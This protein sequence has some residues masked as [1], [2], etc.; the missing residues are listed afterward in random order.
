M[1]KAEAI[2]SLYN[3]REKFILIGLTGRTGAGCS[4]VSE[5]LARKDIDELDLRSYK[6]CDYNNAEE[7]KYSVVY[8]VYKE[9]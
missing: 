4:T 5:I 6:T 8:T 7:R 1:D 2:K 9:E 3:Q